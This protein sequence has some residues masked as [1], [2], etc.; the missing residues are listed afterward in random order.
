WAM[1]LAVVMLPAFAWV[2]VLL[3]ESWGCSRP[4][5]ILI[6]AWLVLNPYVVLFSIN[7][8]TDLLLTVVLGC[9]L[10]IARKASEGQSRWLAL[11]SGA[12]GALA[13][14]VK[15]AALPLLVVGP[16]WFA[17]RRQ[18]RLGLWFGAPLFVTLVSWMTW[19]AR[20]TLPS[21]DRVIIYYTSY[22]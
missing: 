13:F 4:I 12:L 20:H 10:L 11:A 6:C 9:C 5:A 8:M 21:T 1:L 18:F 19:T 17:L 15:T 16:L 7:L 3:L 14:L 22:L 2:C